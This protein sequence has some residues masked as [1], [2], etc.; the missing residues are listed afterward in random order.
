MRVSWVF[1]PGGRS[2]LLSTKV[3]GCKGGEEFEAAE[4]LVLSEVDE[5][6]LLVDRFRVGVEEEEE[7]LCN[8]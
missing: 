5:V 2:T 4:V 8:E 1:C 3:R 6:L 7:V